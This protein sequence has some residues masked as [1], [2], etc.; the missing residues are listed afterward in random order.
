M[1]Y[2]LILI[3][4]TF[5]L[6]VVLYPSDRGRP[7][8]VTLAALA[9]AAA[10]LFALREPRVTGL[11]GFLVL[12]AT[13]KLVLGVTTTVFLACALYLPGYLRLRA[14]RSNRFGTARHAREGRGQSCQ[15]ELHRYSC[16]RRP[17]A[18]C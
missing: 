11:D 5:A 13:G 15:W 18:P 8:L 7:W 9:Q 12:D 2:A 10:V 3:P 4:L 16:T 17:R 1:A 14:E 6:L